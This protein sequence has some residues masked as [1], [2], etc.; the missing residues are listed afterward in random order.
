MD[1]NECINIFNNMVRGD[2]VSFKDKLLPLVSDYL[3]EIK[4]EKSDKIINLIVANPQLIQHT[5]PTV[6][7]YYC[8]KYN[9]LILKQIITP[10]N[11]N[12]L[13]TILYYE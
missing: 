5:I 10:D 13:K 3:T 2:P 12:F 9:I 6:V 1:K 8:R 4:Y 7:E 11:L